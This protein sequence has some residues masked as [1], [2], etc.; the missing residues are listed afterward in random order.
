MTPETYAYFLQS[1]YI[2]SLMQKGGSASPVNFDKFGTIIISKYS[3]HFFESDLFLTSESRK[4]IIAEAIF[5]NSLIVAA[6]QFESLDN[7]LARKR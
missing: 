6:S 7:P 4:L 5:E 2:S 3:C 1:P